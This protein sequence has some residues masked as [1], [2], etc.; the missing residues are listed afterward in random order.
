MN[1][2]GFLSRIAK[3]ALA[4]PALALIP[5]VAIKPEAVEAAADPR[6]PGVLTRADWL[7][8]PNQTWTASTSGVNYGTISLGQKINTTSFTDTAG[9]RVVYSADF[10]PD[11]YR[12]AIDRAL[13]ALRDSKGA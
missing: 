9:E 7:M 2:R 6:D 10:R 12:A 4:L 3:A 5:L 8:R 13:R 11:D 1:R